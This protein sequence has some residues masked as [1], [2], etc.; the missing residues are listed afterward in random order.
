PYP[1]PTW[2]VAVSSRTEHPKAAAKFI[3][4]LLSM[5]VQ[6]EMTSGGIPVNQMSLD[7]WRSFFLDYKVKNHAPADMDEDFVNRYFDSLENL[8]SPVWWDANGNSLLTW[9]AIGMAMGQSFDEAYPPVREKLDEYF[10][11]H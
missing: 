8:R 6:N 11:G 3:W 1:V 5:Q 2:C 4:Y 10:G 9:C 7:Y